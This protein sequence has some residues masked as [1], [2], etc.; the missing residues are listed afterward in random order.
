MKYVGKIRNIPHG[1]TFG[2]I[3]S[4]SDGSDY[5]FHSSQF[6]GI[7]DTLR[8]G[9]GVQFEL[10]EKGGR[11]QAICVEPLPGTPN[12]A[13]RKFGPYLG[14]NLG[15]SDEVR[16]KCLGDIARWK[17]EAKLDDVKRY[18][19]AIPELNDIA[20][21]DASYVIGRKGTGKTALVQYLAETSDS[22]R[23]VSKLTFKNFPFNELY[24]QENESYRRPNQYITIW[25]LII[26]SS[27]CK[28]IAQST[29]CDPLVRDTILKAFPN[30]DSDNLGTIVG[31]WIAGD[32]GISVLGTG[33][34]ISKWFKEKK[35]ITIQEKVENLEQFVVKHMPNQTFLV[36]FDELDEDYKNIFETY[37]KSEYLDLLTSLFKAVQD[38]RSI[39]TTKG[40]KLYPVVF[41]R[42]D[43]YDL[44]QDP[45]KNKWR[46][47]EVDLEWTP[48]SIKGLLSHRLAK[49]VG[50][51]D[52][53]FDILW[54]SLFSREAVTF[55]G[56]KKTTSSFEYI[57]MSTQGRPRDYINYLQE[58]AAL[59]LKR[60]R[61]EISIETI[62]DADKLYSNYLRK[63]LI[64]E[65]HGIIP[66]IGKVL[67]IF[68]ET[69]KWILSISEFRKAYEERAQV[70][71][72]QIKD[73][74][75]ILKTLFYFSIIGNVAK[76]GVHI[77]RHVRP[78]A[79]FNFK[80]K[81]VV[82]R[83]LMKSLQII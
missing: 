77:F 34:N 43:I 67:A 47:F 44:L 46:D 69:R 60:S 65:I 71:A 59:E 24:A 22:N 73:V 48:E 42:D 78:E 56:G 50:Q 82:H 19:F 4:Q 1:K 7:W 6:S 16:E 70:G 9:D 32:F 63:E 35:K 76:V 72:V 74:D 40:H 30:P 55:S 37:N 33:I 2:F 25:K 62:R 36:L 12:R 51:N 80:E 20:T 83:G 79:E 49:V 17:L 21:G 27:V 18:F 57:T 54:Y 14:P 13:P 15:L 10:V 75:M 29:K 45:D 38:V 64:D 61:R 52:E 58:C 5:F 31:K 28:L 68:S 53:D 66:D 23:L 8:T 26:Y 41:L 11:P 81:I 3:H 39:V